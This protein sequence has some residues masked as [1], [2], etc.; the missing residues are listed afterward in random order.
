MPNN[1]P[2]AADRGPRKTLVWDLP[3]RLF[4]WLIVLFVTVSFVTV[5]IGGNAMQYHEWSGFTILT[6]VL[7]RVVWGVIG[8]EPSRF[9]TFLKGPATVWRYAAT[10]L[11]RE[12]ECHLTHNPLGGWSVAALL[13]VLL[14]QAGTGLFANDDIA[15]EG[16]LY[17]WVSKATSDWITQAHEFN[18]GIIEALIALH[19]AAVLFH[20]LYKR[21][22]LIVP[23]LTGDMPCEAEHGPPGMRP[24]WLAAV[25]A[26]FAAAAVY[27]LVR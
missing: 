13:I 27:F 19:L 20:L 25:P 1:L 18:A 7:F 26:A 5:N 10:T 21:V 8:S 22:N 3:T 14:V 12:P 16:P 17:G 2:L 11:R 23:M 4:H 9:K 24:L 6:L 15:T